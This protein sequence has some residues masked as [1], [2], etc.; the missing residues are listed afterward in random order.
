MK[1]TAL[2]AEQVGETPR[3]DDHSDPDAINVIIGGF[4]QDVFVERRARV[5]D[6]LEDGA[7]VLPAAPIL[8][9]AGDS[10][11]PYRPDSELFYLTGFTEPECVL[12]LRGFADEA[13]VVLFSRPRDPKAELWTGARV[14]PEEARSLLSVDE[15][16]SIEELDVQLPSLLEGADRV[17][18]RLGREPRSEVG[19][20]AALKK[21][22]TEGRAKGS[23]P[24]GTMD[25]GVILDDLRLRKD[26]KEIEAI[27]EAAAITV[28]G[29]EAAFAR[30]RPGMGEWEMEAELEATFRRLGAV[31]PAFASIVGSG[32][33]GC[34]LHYIENSRRMEAG[35]LVL[36]DAGAES[37]MYA[38]DV[39]RTVPVSGR[40][41][42]EQRDVY[43]V[44]EAA[45]KEAVGTIRPGARLSDVHDGVVRQLVRGLLELGVLE[46][47][48]E[49]LIEAEAYKP[50][51]PHRASHW[52][53][54]DTHDVGDYARNGTSRQLETGMVL[55]V[56]PGLYF[57][58][59]DEETPFV[60]TGIRIEDDVLVT[61]DG[62]EILTAGLPTDPERVAALV[63]TEVA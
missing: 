16:R 42:P 37:R 35:D 11:L 13:R 14:G 38:S 1:A 58:P 52:L 26:P 12:V 20:L 62:A 25:P 31:G 2:T 28:R 33:N 34:V 9:R 50:F 19:V 29:F 53:G 60:G 6:A 8:V 55:T 46:G 45:R 27:R 49:G 63:G 40:F 18:F 56:E 15:G 41:S 54:L 32:A 3:L 5:L 61:D 51:F 24:R 17:F 59:S 4:P 7:M 30:L 44:V 36:V 48:E 47:G 21:A 57:A 22:R 39:S 43:E 23:G 10:E